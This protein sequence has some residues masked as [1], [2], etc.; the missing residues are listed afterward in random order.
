VSGTASVQR[1]VEGLRLPTG[2]NEAFLYLALLRHS[3]EYLVQPVG[4]HH[5]SEWVLDRR[6]DLADPESLRWVAVQ[7]SLDDR[8]PRVGGPAS[9]EL[10]TRDRHIEGTPVHALEV[11]ALREAP[12]REGWSALPAGASFD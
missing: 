10:L 3:M 1:C 8:L 5:Q 11:S 2:P 6:R 4:A 7:E 12:E 9:I